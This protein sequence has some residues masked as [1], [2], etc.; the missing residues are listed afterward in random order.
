[1]DWRNIKGKKINQ[2]TQINHKIDFNLVDKRIQIIV[3]LELDKISKKQNELVK[4][5]KLYQWL[6]F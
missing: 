5:E 6:Y 1:M 4:N 3:K 2:Q